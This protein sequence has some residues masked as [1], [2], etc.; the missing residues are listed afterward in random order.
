[1]LGTFDEMGGFGLVVERGETF[2]WHYVVLKNV[3]LWKN[4]G[5]TLGRFLNFIE[6]V[7][8]V[9]TDGIDLFY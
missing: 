1:M 6:Q 4:H 8:E 2:G 9:C 7:L 5:E 3:N